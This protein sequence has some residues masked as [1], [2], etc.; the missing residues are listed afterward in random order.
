MRKAFTL[1]ELL[2]VISIIGL[3]IAILLPAL[4]SA[5]EAARQT[6]C[7][8][9]VR[10]LAQSYTTWHVDRNY[11]PHPYAPTGG[12][13]EDY[14]IN[15]L[16]DYGFQEDQ[17]LCPEAATVDES[18]EPDTNVWFGTATGAWR[19]ARPVYPDIPWVASYT[20]NGWLHSTGGPNGSGDDGRRYGTLDKIMVT[21]EVPL[22]GD[23][24]W[25]SAWPVESD[26]APLSLQV[27]RTVTPNSGN[28]STFA[29]SR[30]K[31]TCNLSYADGSAGALRIENLWS[32]SWHSEWVPTETVAMPAN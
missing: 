18:N 22:F 8:A 26:P 20:F 24:M 13:A 28:M 23:G 29:S 32:I 5:R 17:R 14:W 30:H 27:P 21:S 1:I 4:S 25:R 9:N 15:A 6:Q 2:V 7:L 10:S 31:S 11:E 3:L 19:E 16:L 12:V